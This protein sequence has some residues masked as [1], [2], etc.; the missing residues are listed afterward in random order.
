MVTVSKCQKYELFCSNFLQEKLVSLPK[1]NVF[2]EEVT[3]GTLKP[4]DAKISMNAWLVPNLCVVLMLYV[5][6]SQE[7]MNVNVHQDFQEIPSAVV[8]NAQ[9][10]IH[11]NEF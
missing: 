7:V 9:V 11:F 10:K 5:K 4:E 8:K 6:I 1:E 2:A 3:I